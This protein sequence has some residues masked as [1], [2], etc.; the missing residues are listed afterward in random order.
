MAAAQGTGIYNADFR[1]QIVPSSQPCHW[2]RSAAVFSVMQGETQSLGRCSKG[3]RAPEGQALS[4][5]QQLA[6]GRPVRDVSP[7]HP[8]YAN[9]AP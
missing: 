5:R 8:S 1:R 4:R 9:P 2:A 6:L 7:G 3:S